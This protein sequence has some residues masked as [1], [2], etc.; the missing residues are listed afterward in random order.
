M[1]FRSGRAGTG[2]AFAVEGLRLADVT[3]A[4]VRPALVPAACPAEMAATVA[5]AFPLRVFGA[6]RIGASDNIRGWS[7]DRGVRG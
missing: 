7:G 6:R 1:L 5:F 4:A 2:A 3:A